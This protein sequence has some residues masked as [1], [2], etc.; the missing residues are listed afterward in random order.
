MHILLSKFKALVV[1]SQYYINAF[2][3]DNQFMFLYP[4]APY[5]PPYFT[6]AFFPHCKVTS[7]ARLFHATA[8]GPSDQYWHFVVNWFHHHFLPIRRYCHKCNVYIYRQWSIELMV[9]LLLK[10]KRRQS[11]LV[12]GPPETSHHPKLKSNKAAIHLS[13]IWCHLHEKWQLAPMF[14]LQNVQSEGLRELIQSTP[15]LLP[16][17]T[18]NVYTVPWR[19]ML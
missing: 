10:V 5:P 2:F 4:S 3:F 11:H 1:D 18:L 16:P 6:F 8:H 19:L 12:E 13:V 14:H 17:P 9:L 15:K 7:P